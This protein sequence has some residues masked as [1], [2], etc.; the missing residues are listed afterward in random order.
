MLRLTAM[1]RRNPELTHDEFLEHWRDVHAQLMSRPAIARHIVRYEQHAVAPGLP[2][3]VGSAGY[4]G[5]AMQW[6][7]DLE[8]FTSFLS[9]PDYRDHIAPDEGRLLDVSAT[10]WLMTEEPVVVIDGD[11]AS[12]GV[13]R[14]VPGRADR[15][16]RPGDRSGL[17]SGTAADEAE[18]DGEEGGGPHG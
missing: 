4:D 13:P 2:G 1:L 7:A 17:E 3:W 18:P 15:A 10:Q 5:V 14:P 16:D 8:A 11:P 12:D 6:F 9:E